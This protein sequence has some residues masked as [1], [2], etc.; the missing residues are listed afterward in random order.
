MNPADIQTIADL[1]GASSVDSI[2]DSESQLIRV[3]P[4][5]VPEVSRVVALAHR[6]GWSLVPI[7]S[8]SQ[9]RSAAP[10]GLGSGVGTDVELLRALRSTRSGDQSAPDLVIALD[11]LDQV[12][13][14]SPAD[15][16]ASVQCGMPLALAQSRLAQH[17]QW[18]P[19]DPAQVSSSTVGGT[20]AMNRFGPRRLR[21][22]TLRDWVIGTTLVRSDGAIVKA[23]GMVV[24]NVSG[25]D[26]SKLYIGSQGSLGILVQAN[27]K[28][29]PVPISRAWL[30]AP[31]TRAGDDQVWNAFREF[32]N[33]DW[34]L[35]SAVLNRRWSED[36]RSSD[37]LGSRLRGRASNGM[38]DGGV[39]QVDSFALELEG[40]GEA[41]ANRRDRALDIMHRT[42]F[43]D[44]AWITENPV[45]DTHIEPCDS[46]VRLHYPPAVH[47]EL[48]ARIRTLPEKARPTFERSLLGSG[49]TWFFRE[50]PDVIGAPRT[51]PDMDGWAQVRSIVD[52]AGGFAV[53][54]RLGP[55]DRERQAGPVANHRLTVRAPAS[56]A[57]SG[58]H[59]RSSHH[60]HD[61][62]ARI[63][64]ALNPNGTI[65]AGIALPSAWVAG[66]ESRQ[67]SE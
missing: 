2:A 55:R 49:V 66:E 26:L 56:D 40:P 13:E 62:E 30:R 57:V 53:V 58:T 31:A 65:Q 11:R 10:S 17:G 36:V 16:V 38:E 32:W 4:V 51:Q 59:D 8:G 61:L 28:L 27:F 20:L 67:R 21:Y 54:E 43:P 18:I 12:I 35:A 15:L 37:S 48:M 50:L 33:G 45:C 5:S 9:I 1:V 19:V 63:V 6:M 29:T 64:H 24:K 42:G 22:G 52:E 23:G 41:L 60:G 14:H 47:L 7:G 46:I 25:Y 34:P 39:E 3:R 44:V